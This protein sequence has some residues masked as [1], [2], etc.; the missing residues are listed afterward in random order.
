MKDYD[1]MTSKQLINEL[2]DNA[3]HLAVV[4]KTKTQ[5]KVRVATMQLILDNIKVLVDNVKD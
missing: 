2:I 5:A 1:K 4:D 3:E